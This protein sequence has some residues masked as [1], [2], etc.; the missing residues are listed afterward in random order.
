MTVGLDLGTSGIRSLQPRAG[1]LRGAQVHTIATFVRDDAATR[2]LL[3]QAQTDTLPGDGHLV[4]LGD[5]ALTWARV[6]RTPV[7]PLLPEGKLSDEPADHQLLKLLVRSVLP[8]P[9]FEHDICCLTVPS[10]RG[11]DQDDNPE[12]T[13][14]TDLIQELGYRPVVIGQ[15]QALILA[16]LGAEGFTGLSMVFGAAVTEFSF[17]HHGRE[18]ARCVVSRGGNWIDEQLAADSPDYV[19]DLQSQRSLDL[20][21]IRRRKESGEAAELPL[22]FNQAVRECFTEYL[23]DVIDEA[24]RQFQRVSTLR[25]MPEPIQ[26]IYSGGSSRWAGFDGLVTQIIRTSAWPV[27]LG[28]IRRAETSAFTIARGCLIHAELELTVGQERVA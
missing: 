18:L 5:A 10:G 28:G 27:G 23:G 8:A 6:L 2:Q 21:G 26:V 22:E 16:E 12:V 19:W 7:R 9:S 4:L 25:R 1:S 24:V 13:F 15:G 3:A 17:T 14:F 11:G 20:A